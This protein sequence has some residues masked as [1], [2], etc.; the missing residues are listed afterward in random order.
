MIEENYF[1]EEDTTAFLEN[2]IF[3]LIYSNISD[4][5]FDFRSKGHCWDYMLLTHF[6][7]KGIMLLVQCRPFS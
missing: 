4:I 3:L 2:E 6:T 7:E 1:K 5:C